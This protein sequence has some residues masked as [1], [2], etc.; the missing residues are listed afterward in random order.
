MFLEILW[1]L[2]CLSTEITLVRLQRNV[3]TDMRCDVITLYSGSTARVP[4]T[5]QVEIVGR[6][7]TYMTLTDVVLFNVSVED[8]RR[9]EETRM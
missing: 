8:D 4:T 6:L 3:N 2:E 1:S 5:S 9:Q 7:A